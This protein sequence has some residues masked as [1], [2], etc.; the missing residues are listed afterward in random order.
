MDS[1]SESSSTSPAELNGLD[2]MAAIQAHLR[3]KKRLGDYI[4]GNS[5]EQLDADVVGADHKCAL[6]KWI[7]GVGAE[8]HGEREIFQRLRTIHAA[9]HRSAGEIVRAVDA[10]K[11]E[12]A[13]H[14]LH[15]GE[16]PKYSHQ[17]KAELA[18]LSL[19]IES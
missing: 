14:M 19:E 8:Y 18:R 10:G 3:W 15:Y 11:E 12:E 5:G 4:A 9:F 7:Y 16:Y 13:S 2:V 17:V 6:G 1:H